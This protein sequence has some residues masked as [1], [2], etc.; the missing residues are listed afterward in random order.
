MFY[1]TRPYVLF[2]GV[3][4]FRAWHWLASVAS[5]GLVSPG[6]ATDGVTPIFSSNNW[7][8]FFCSLLSLF[9][10]HS[11]V[12]LRMVSPRAFFTCP[13]HIFF[14]RVSSL[15]GVT[16]GGPP[17]PPPSDATG[18]SACSRCYTALLLNVYSAPAQ[19]SVSPVIN[20][21]CTIDCIA[22]QPY[23]RHLLSI[24]CASDARPLTRCIIAISVL[25]LNFIFFTH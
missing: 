23:C 24:N 6:A 15:E 18:W 12:T 7:R 1:L 4:V 21:Q 8:P 17:P 3:F 9:L 20:S 13:S 10:F 16:R 14:I 22:L 5:L 25:F 2:V 11:G 19:P